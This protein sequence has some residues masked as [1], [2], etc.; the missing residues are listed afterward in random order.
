M[1]AISRPLLSNLRESFN[2]IVS[3]RGYSNLKRVLNFDNIISAEISRFSVFFV[4]KNAKISFFCFEKRINFGFL[5]NNFIF[6]QQFRKLTLRLFAVEF[7]CTY[8]I[9][10]KDGRKLY[11]KKIRGSFFFWSLLELVFWMLFLCIGRYFCALG[12]FLD[13]FLK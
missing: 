10:S 7:L 1:R 4:F 13:T 3:I 5:I 11:S 6:F 8:V 12:A 2:S 9:I